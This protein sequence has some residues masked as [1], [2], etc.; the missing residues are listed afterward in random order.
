ME[1]NGIE[2][3]GRI[4]HLSK[5][6]VEEEVEPR[7]GVLL[8]TRAASIADPECLFYTKSSHKDVCD[9]PIHTPV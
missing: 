1:K 7:T 3:R 4:C 2:G 5:C 6:F 8:L 9:S